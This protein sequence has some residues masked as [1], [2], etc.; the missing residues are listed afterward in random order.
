MKAITA[1]RLHEG[2]VVYLTAEGKWVSSLAQARLFSDEA[3]VAAALAEAEQAVAAR[4]IVAPYAFAVAQ[5]AQGVIAALS[6]R[7]QIRAS[8]NPTIA[9]D[10]GS[11]Q[12]N[13]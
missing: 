3:A 10:H 4:R 1:N 12:E 5:D 2:D 11:W 8:R 13:R 7:E 9:V 6:T